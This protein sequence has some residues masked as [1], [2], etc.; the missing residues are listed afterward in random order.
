MNDITP[1]RGPTVT[2]VKGLDRP[3]ATQMASPSS[4]RS[5]DEAEISVVGQMLSRLSD[6]PV[7]QELV[8]RVR[9]EIAAG[10]YETPDKLQAAMESLLQDWT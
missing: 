2:P 7:R 5:T 9:Q 4:L 1:V 3:V 6:L 10:T 8:D